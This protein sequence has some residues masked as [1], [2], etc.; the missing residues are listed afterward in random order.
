MYPFSIT[1]KLA[2]KN[3]TNEHARYYIA[4]LGEKKAIKQKLRKE[5]FQNA[6]THREAMG[7]HFDHNNKFLRTEDA[8]KNKLFYKRNAKRTIE[9]TPSQKK[10]INV[11]KI[12][13]D[14]FFPFSFCLI[15]L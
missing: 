1:E 14:N 10:Q 7:F 2:E 12:A 6:Q 4:M 15:C 9:E 11:E 3:S 13:P 5:T 8:Q